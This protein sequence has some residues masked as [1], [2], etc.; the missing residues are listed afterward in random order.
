M[1]TYYSAVVVV[2]AL[3]VVAYAWVKWAR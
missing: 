1:L 2:C 3:L